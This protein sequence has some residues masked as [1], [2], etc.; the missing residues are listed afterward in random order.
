ML[1]ELFPDSKDFTE[2]IFK[3]PKMSKHF[4]AMLLTVVVIIKLLHWH[5]KIVFC[6]GP[7]RVH[8]KTSE[9]KSLDNKLEWMSLDEG[10][11][12]NNKEVQ[13]I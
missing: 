9:T 3:V 12:Q 8:I 7:G 2:A 5:S 10:E 6:V 4:S 1:K 13:K 11:F